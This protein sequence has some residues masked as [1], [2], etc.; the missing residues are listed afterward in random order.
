LARS[1]IHEDEQDMMMKAAELLGSPVGPIAWGR[2][3]KS[4]IPLAIYVIPKAE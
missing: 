3:A 1:A 4:K 2:G